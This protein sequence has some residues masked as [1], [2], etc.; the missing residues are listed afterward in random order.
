MSDIQVDSLPIDDILSGS[1]DPPKLLGRS[2][3]LPHDSYLLAFNVSIG[4]SMS[5][6]SEFSSGITS[7]HIV[8]NAATYALPYLFLMGN[9][10]LMR[11]QKQQK[12][13]TKHSCARCIYCQAPKLSWRPARLDASDMGVI[14]RRFLALELCVVFVYPISSPMRAGATSGL[15]RAYMSKPQ[16]IVR[17]EL[18]LRNIDTTE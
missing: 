12:H 2:T 3:S 4:T 5:T 11:I 8:H 14:L 6:Y 7:V 17:P 1:L 15:Q 16:N 13:S 18:R 10:S 9:V